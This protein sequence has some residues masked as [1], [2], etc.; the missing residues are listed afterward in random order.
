MRRVFSYFL[1]FAVLCAVSAVVAYVPAAPAY[2][3]DGAQWQIQVFNVDD[4]SFVDINGTRFDLNGEASGTDIGFKGDSGWRDITAAVAST[5]SATR[6]TMRTYN[7][8]GGY[9]WGFRIAR[10]LP[11]QARQ[12]LFERVAGTAGVTGA[13]GNDQTKT[14]QYVFDT[15]VTIGS[16][17]PET[18]TPTPA[19]SPVISS[20]T[21]RPVITAGFGDTVTIQGEGFGSRTGSAA[22]LF[23]YQPAQ[24]G[25]AAQY[26]P[27]TA[28]DTWTDTRIVCQVPVDTESDLPLTR[29]G[30]FRSASSGPMMVRDSA[31]HTSNTKDIKVSFS[32]L[33]RWA[34]PV[35]T[36]YVYSN[37]NAFWGGQ[38]VGACEKWNYANSGF[39]FVPNPTTLV[40][41]KPFLGDG[42]N[43][44]YWDY[45]GSDV[46]AQ[47]EHW[48]KGSRTPTEVDIVINKS[49]NWGTYLNPLKN[50]LEAV[51]LHH[52][53]HFVGLRDLWGDADK[54]NTMYGWIDW[55]SGLNNVIWIDM[56][57]NDAAWGAQRIYP[58]TPSGST[59]FFDGFEGQE[60][61]WRVATDHYT[62]SPN[63]GLTSYRAAT[64]A[65]SAY[66]VGSSISAPGPYVNNMATLMYVGPFDLSGATGGTL[67]WD[68]WFDTELS[69]DK[70]W[71][72]LF[73]GVPS[74]G[75][76]RGVGWW[77]TSGGWDHEVMDMA[78][79]SMLRPLLGR[80]DVYI[81]MQFYSDGSAVKQGAY[82]DNVKLTV[83][84]RAYATGARAV[85]HVDR[86]QPMSQGR[87]QVESTCESAGMQPLEQSQP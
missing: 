83:Q 41:A 24:S 19:R 45:L 42:Y 51:A 18:P 6:I 9:T 57:S 62:T 68:V 81:G 70:V 3:S 5:G 65:H 56:L 10:T 16:L 13:N 27:A 17:L 12:I 64:G 60:F 73:G 30:Y 40:P 74:G 69:C 80:R 63:W 49:K 2:A 11:G 4:V 85:G 22:V 15:T 72:G 52:L 79:N 77:G 20:I 66:C 29:I 23:L 28:Y 31:G 84:S 54:T 36:V 46:L 33:W 86:T 35:Q 1:V 43:E 59:V 76:G 48:P 39:R 14:E 71:V 58:S 87:L 25:A 82:V 61:A 26:I 67:E 44:I 75:N 8:G 47:T 32:F 37:G 7:H 21:T 34:N 78:S 53:G 38:L 55:Y 50:D